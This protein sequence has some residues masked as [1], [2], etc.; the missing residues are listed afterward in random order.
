MTASPAV[1]MSLGEQVALLGVVTLAF[2]VETV[3]GFGATVVVVSLGALFL[4]LELLLPTFVPVN[5]AL[6]FWLV[7]RNLH[8]V[9]WR[10]LGRRLLP[11]LLVGMAVGMG[12]LAGLPSR[13]MLIVF[14]A[15]VVGLSVRELLAMRRADA[16]PPAVLSAPVAALVLA[17]G[18]V[19]HGVFGTGGPLIVFVLARQLHEKG[20]FRATL[21]V[22]WVLLNGLLVLGYWVGDRLDGSTLRGS[23]LLVVALMVGLVVGQRVHERVDAI[24]FRKGLFSMLLIAGFVLSL[25]S[26]LT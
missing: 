23:A 26:L 4:P 19:V 20:A 6:S 18:G 1:A 13:R 11:A 3:V 12:L 2:T 17:S 16:A 25:R 9:Q 5:L 22:V 24:R 15:L 14:G 21:A 8:D 10:L 7:G